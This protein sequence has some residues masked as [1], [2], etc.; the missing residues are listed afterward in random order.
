[1][2]FEKFFRKDKIKIKN[3]EK[4]NVQLNLATSSIKN[5]LFQIT[6]KFKEFKF[7]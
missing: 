4:S 6:K 1:M 2:F 5:K 7:R 3:S